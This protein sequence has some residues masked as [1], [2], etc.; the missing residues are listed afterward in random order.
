MDIQISSLDLA[1]FTPRMTVDPEYAKKLSDDIKY[2]G[3]QRPILV[4]PNP[5]TPN[6]YQVI[7][8]VHRAEACKLA[9]LD[10]IKAEVRQLSDEEATFWA[11]HYNLWRGR[12]LTQLEQGRQLWR[13]QKEFELSQEEIGKK[14]QR[15]QQWVSERIGLW[16][17]SSAAL[18]E[19]ITAHAV[20]FSHARSV[21]QLPEV[22]QDM[23]LEKV[24]EQKLN[25]R[26][27]AIIV[28][29]LKRAE[30]NQEKQTLL[31]ETP[32]K[33]PFLSAQTKQ[34]LQL[35]KDSAPMIETF[36]CP[37]CAKPI[38]VNFVTREIAKAEDT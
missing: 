37:H 16:L 4:R 14:F 25:A 19:S 2:N 33:S 13:L 3:L 1:L 20:S 38:I 31:N 11:L 34:E 26:Q 23:V 24:K 30:T 21:A 9:G 27:T 12:G 32:L 22:D 18:K 5:R 7:D 15:S 29:R 28:N 6:R 8:G 35:L 10:I 17:R 36:P